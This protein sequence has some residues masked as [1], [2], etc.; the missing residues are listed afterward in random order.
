[1]PETEPIE[2]TDLERVLLA[3]EKCVIVSSGPGKMLFV[4]L[5]NELRSEIN[6]RAEFEKAEFE[7]IKDKFEVPAITPEPKRPFI[8]RLM[9]R[10]T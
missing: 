1:M 5:A 7:R 9:D 6:N 2:P 3:V 8:E 10:W 4:M